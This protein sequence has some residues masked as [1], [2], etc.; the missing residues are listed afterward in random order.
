[1]KLR[2]GRLAAILAALGL[3]TVLS[4]RAEGPM[5]ND[6]AGTLGPGK[7]KVEGAWNKLHDTQTSTLLLGFGPV[8]SLEL[9]IGGSRLEDDTV[10]LKVNGQ[11]LSV[12]WVP[13]SQGEVTAGARLDY[14]RVDDGS[15][16][17][18][19]TTLVG[20]LT[21][22]SQAGTVL[23]FNAGRS[24]PGNG[25]AN[26]FYGVGAEL[27]LGPRAQLTFDY[28]RDSATRTRVDQIGVRMEVA[29]SLKLYA[30]G[31]KATGSKRDTTVGFN[32][33]F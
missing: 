14:E 2:G 11:F 23:H 24:K 22:R 15:A 21:W 4:A 28:T 5:L 7:F 20:L 26:N 6:D 8:R 16:R 32:W 9:N 29:Q 30:A 31:A 3:G 17:A 25:S 33:E 18:N 1:M 19:F 13:Y 10:P 12:K 27:P